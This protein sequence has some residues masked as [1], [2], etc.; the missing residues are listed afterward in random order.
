MSDAFILLIYSTPESDEES[1]KDALFD[2]VQCVIKESLEI[3]ETAREVAATC[4]E[5]G[6]KKV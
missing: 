2:T 6:L 5:Q 1:S 3:N 4:T